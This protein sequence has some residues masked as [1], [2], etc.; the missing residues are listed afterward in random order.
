MS[1]STSVPSEAFV[2]DIHCF[3]ANLDF[4]LMAPPYH[5]KNNMPKT[6]T[7]DTPARTLTPLSTPQDTKIARLPMTTPAAKLPLDRSYAALRLAKY[8]R[9]DRLM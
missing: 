3:S 5:H 7:A 9:Y 1:C 2:N 6:P 8:L 4:D